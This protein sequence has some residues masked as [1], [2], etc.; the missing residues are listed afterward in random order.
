MIEGREGKNHII[1]RNRERWEK[2]GSNQENNKLR[3][4]R[5]EKQQKGEEKERKKRY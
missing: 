2:G 1:M 5:K 4:E 3:N